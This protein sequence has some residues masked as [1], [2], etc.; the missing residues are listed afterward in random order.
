MR[1]IHFGTI[2]VKIGDEIVFKKNGRVFF[3][4]S[5]NG[6]P[7]NG[8]TL[9]ND[10]N[11]KNSKLYSLLHITK[12]MMGDEYNEGEDIFSLWTF[13]GE[14]LRSIFQREKQNV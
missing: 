11:K 6:T 10:P 13:K 8:G 7:E 14:S 2:G 3:V 1:K 12:K 4:S 5:G 9:V